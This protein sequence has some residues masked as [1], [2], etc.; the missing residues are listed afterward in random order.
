MN[1][2]D[3]TLLIAAS[4]EILPATITLMLISVPELILK[5]LLKV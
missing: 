3:A 2:A 4:G 1:K 5:D